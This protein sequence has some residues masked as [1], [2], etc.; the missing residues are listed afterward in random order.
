MD[1]L[2]ALKQISEGVEVI[3]SPL[4]EAREDDSEKKKMK[5]A[6]W[7]ENYPIK[8]LWVTSAGM[9]VYSVGEGM[10]AP[11]LMSINDYLADDWEVIGEQEVFA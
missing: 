4:M 7:T 5:R 2:E 11:M 6:N 1:F 9:L 8:Y 10:S 3:P